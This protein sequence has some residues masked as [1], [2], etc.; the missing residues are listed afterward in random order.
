MQVGEKVREGDEDDGDDDELEGNEEEE[1]EGSKITVIQIVPASTVSNAATSPTPAVMFEYS[2]IRILGE[3][4]LK[5]A[6]GRQE[7]DLRHAPK[8]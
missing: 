8:K 2:R 4:G 1:D 7:P 6:G 3:K 5:R